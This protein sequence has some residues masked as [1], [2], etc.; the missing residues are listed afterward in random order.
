M[1]LWRAGRATKR[2]SRDHDATTAVARRVDIVESTHLTGIRFRDQTM[3]DN[4]RV[5]QYFQAT[6]TA[7]VEYD[8]FR[9]V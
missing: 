7:L 1:A 5:E 9:T 8:A 4:G 6:V 2:V 3:T